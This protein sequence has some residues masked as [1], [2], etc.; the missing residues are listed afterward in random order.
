MNETLTHEVL[1]AMIDSG[2]SEF[3][4][5][6]GS[7]NV[8]FV[9]ALSKE[10]RLSVYYHFDEHSAAYFAL[11]RSRFLQCPVAVITTSGSAAAELL[12][13]AMEAHY[14]GVPLV[15]VTA[16]RPRSFRGSGA[17]QAAEQVGLFGCYAHFSA[18]IC[19]GQPFSLTA[20]KQHGPAHLNVCLEE[21]Q[22]QPPFQGRTLSLDKRAHI[23][24]NP[25]DDFQK[26]NE[27][28]DRF[29]HQVERPLA[30]VSTLK[31]EEQEAV[32]RFL[33]ELNCPV[34]IEG[35]SGLRE[36]KRLQPLSI[37][38]TE[39][40][41][42]NAQAAG[43]AIDGILRIGGVP[44]H[45]IWRDLEY[46]KERIKVC[47]LS[48]LPFSGLSWSRGV[49]EAPV[50]LF[51]EQYA[52]PR[53][54]SSLLAERWIRAEQQYQKEL[55]SL[56]AEE[57]TAEASLVHAIS[58][59]IPA[60]SHVYLGNSLPIREWDLAAT[61]EQKQFQVRANR[62]V[63][64]IDGQISTFLGLSSPGRENW[65]LVG[66]LTALY[67]MPGF[68]ICSQ[69][70][71]VPITVALINNGGGQIFSRLFKAKEMI[72]A[73]ALSF[74]PLAKMW[75]FAYQRLERIPAQLPDAAA[76]FLEIVPD[77][78]ATRRFWDKFDA[79]SRFKE[80]DLD[81]CLAATGL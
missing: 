59:L 26:G 57:P 61:L 24:K 4:V 48:P 14:S 15:L 37:R 69:M 58:R 29:F 77:P 31:P 39:K 55:E 5:C 50:G 23:H 64:G 43:Y 68:W 54:Y 2:V 56:F 65:A 9:E 73:H 34:L 38:C 36:E 20:W 18:D 13:A 70:P 35:I 42:Q 11:G 33:L 28:L 6:A 71:S 16:D 80:E 76:R 62:G 22:G 1:Q 60:H 8:S 19:A 10:K 53:Q 46:Q 32:S 63:N 78:D 30:I 72:N 49:V 45:R 75:S 27:L 17:P 44:T 51:L 74:E 12:P 40:I 67:D 79:I 47:V 52:A 41:L 66:D 7:R 21:P 25:S 3:V 81:A